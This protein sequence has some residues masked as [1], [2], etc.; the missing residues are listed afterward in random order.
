M[1]NKFLYKCDKVSV[2]HN[3][4]KGFN[5]LANKKINKDELISISAVSLVGFDEIKEDSILKNYPMYWNDE[6]DCIAF[7]IINLLNHSDNP[8]VR[9]ENDYDN[10]LIKAFAIKDIEINEELVMKYRCKIWFEVID[11]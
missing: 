3:N 5:L 10:K 8:N 9:I 7:G 1:D 2:F 6:K 4:R 11:G